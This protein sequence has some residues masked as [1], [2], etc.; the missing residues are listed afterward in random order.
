M[1]TDTPVLQVRQGPPDLLDLQL[2]STD[3]EDM[4]ITPGIIQPL[5]ERKVIV[6]HRGH[7]TFQVLGQASTFTLSGMR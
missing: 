7:L 2:P 6:D 3:S 4:K 1:D 5:K